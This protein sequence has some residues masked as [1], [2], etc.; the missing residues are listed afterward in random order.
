MITT[1]FETFLNIQLETMKAHIKDYFQ[2]N[3]YIKFIEIL[4]GL[5]K[6]PLKGKQPS[7]CKTSVFCSVKVRGISEEK[8]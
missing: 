5:G 7:S 6:Q 3:I 8:I 4:K 2:S 1:G